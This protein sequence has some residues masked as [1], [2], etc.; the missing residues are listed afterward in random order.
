MNQETKYIKSS[1]IIIYDPL[2]LI[3]KCLTTVN[4]YNNIEGNYI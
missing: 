1:Q 4:N 2:T 3:R